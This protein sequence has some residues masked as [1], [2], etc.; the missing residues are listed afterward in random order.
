MSNFK[1]YSRFRRPKKLKVVPFPNPMLKMQSEDV[2]PKNEPDFLKLIDDMAET[3]YKEEG[4]GLAAI[5]VGVAKNFFVYDDSDEQNNPRVLCNPVI[6]SQSDVMVESEEGCLSFPGIYFPVSRPE[7][8]VV[9]GLDAQGEPLHI[10]AEGFLARLLQH[11]MDHLKG[12]VILDRATPAVR[13]R[14]MREHYMG[15]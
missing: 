9:E 13:K 1:K 10:E 5:Q 8:V 11:E 15:K 6:L 3:M 4:V 12:I 2:D 7:T 14:V